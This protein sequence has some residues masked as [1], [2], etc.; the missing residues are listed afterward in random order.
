MCGLRHL[1]LSERHAHAQQETTRPD[2]PGCGGRLGT[3]QH[4]RSLERARRTDSSAVP[5]PQAV[6]SSYDRAE[7]AADFVTR[8]AG[9]AERGLV[10]ATQ[11]GRAIAASSLELASSAADAVTS[12]AAEGIQHSVGLGPEA[13]QAAAHYGATIRAGRQQGKDEAASGGG[14]SGAGDEKQ[15]GKKQP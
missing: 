3:S 8:A 5:L 9:A 6:R 14:G 13:R 7:A 12:A 10:S 1:G 15:R 4:S 2:R 11:E